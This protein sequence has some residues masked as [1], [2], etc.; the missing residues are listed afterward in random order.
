M[1][2]VT[3][4]MS[5]ADYLASFKN[6]SGA[7]RKSSGR[8]LRLQGLPVAVDSAGAMPR[9]SSAAK[10]RSR[11]GDAIAALATGRT[12]VD[13]EVAQDGAERAII[14]VH[15]GETL[16][17]NRAANI[18]RE[19][20]KLSQKTFSRYKHTCAERMN[21]AAML[22]LNLVRKHGRNRFNQE[23]GLTHISY[24]R[25]VGQKNQLLDEDA[26]VYSFKYIL[27]GLVHAGVLVDDSRRY[28]RIKPAEQNVGKECL[29]VIE[30]E[31]KGSA[32]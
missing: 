1:A 6:G 23:F 16:P 12:E 18:G 30:L 26:V 10:A 2:D 22:L 19:Q 31:T 9:V 25:Q 8:M 24:T 3:P 27:D 13:Y 11:V 21:E 29:L 7:A 15:G 17:P 20:S 5:A 14:R 28:I 4:R 32:S